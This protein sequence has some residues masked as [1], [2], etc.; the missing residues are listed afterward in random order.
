MK[1]E[2]TTIKELFERLGGAKQVAQI[3]STGP[4]AVYMAVNRGSIPYRWRIPLMK[5]ASRRELS[6]SSDL[7][8]AA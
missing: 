3:V 6:V 5:E 1:G 2:I 7:F 8:E 4:T